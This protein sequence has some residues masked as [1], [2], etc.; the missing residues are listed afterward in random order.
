MGTRIYASMAGVVKRSNKVKST[1]SFRKSKQQN[2]GFGGLV[3]INYDNV[4]LNGAYAHL[5]DVYVKKGEKVK[6]GQLIGL[7]GRTGNAN[8][9]HQ[10]AGDDHLHYGRF[11]GEYKGG[12]LRGKDWENPL[13]SLNEPCPIAE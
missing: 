11:P 1:K 12:S 4:G 9:A 2:Y 10:P 5:S 3:V 7:A 6:A 13:K 8:N